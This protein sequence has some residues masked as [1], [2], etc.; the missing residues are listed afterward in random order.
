MRVTDK[1]PLPLLSYSA[2]HPS[3]SIQH[4]TSS[5]QRK[6]W[7]EPHNLFTSSLGPPP[8]DSPIIIIELLFT[9]L[10]AADSLSGLIPDIGIVNLD[11]FSGD[12]LVFGLIVSLLLMQD[13]SDR[14]AACT[15]GDSCGKIDKSWWFDISGCV[16]SF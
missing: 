3:F 15:A 11:L 13:F 9:K 6:L 10:E 1:Y 2:H 4:S 12:V 5:G 7:M 8:P 16:Y 14:D